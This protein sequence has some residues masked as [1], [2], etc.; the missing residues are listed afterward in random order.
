[1]MNVLIVDDEALARKRIR[2]MIAEIDG[3]DVVDEAKNGQQA[4][5]L[6][7]QLQPE[8]VLMDIRMPGIDGLEAA[9]AITQTAQPPAIIYCTAFSDHALQAFESHAVD[10][11]LKPVTT[12]R[13]QEALSAA[14]K[15]SRAQLAVS[16]SADDTS[17]RQHICA[18]VRGNLVLVAIEDIYYFHAD[19]KYVTVCHRQGEL[20]I[21]ETLLSLESE[22]EGRFIRVHRN[23]L[24]ARDKIDGMVKS[25][26]SSFITF[27][28][29][30]GQIEISRRHL[31][32][33]RK[34]IKAL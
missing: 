30:D 5:D 31:P 26:S 14:T 20:L 22:F 32:T 4:I 28:D 24:V 9:R 19:Q 33:V 16:T 8:I 27:H 1:M 21:E 25:E 18:R 3:F 11:L 6:C 10:Y 23:A 12:E 29:I 17:E 13:L 7:K 34:L 2:R 15:S